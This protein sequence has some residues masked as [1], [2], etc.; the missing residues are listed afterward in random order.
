M[1]AAFLVCI[2]LAMSSVLPVN[3]VTIPDGRALTPAGFTVPVDSFVTDEVLSPDGNWLAVVGQGSGAVDVISTHDSRLKARLPIPGATA[4]AWTRTGLYVARGYSGRVSRFAYAGP[5]LQLAPLPDLDA[6]AG[7]INGVADE[8]VSHRLALARTAAREVDVFDDESGRMLDVLPT[9]GQPYRVGFGGNTL[10][11]TLYDSDHVRAWRLD[12]PGDVHDI[13]TGAHPSALLVDGKRFFVANSDGN[14][15]VIINA[16]LMLERRFSLASVAGSLPGQT[17]AGMALSADGAQLYVTE[18]GMNDV[19]VVDVATGRI[20][21]RIPT[22]WYPTAVASL[23]RPTVG[24][25]DTRMRQQLW[26]ADAK[27]SGSQP[28]P[29]GEWDGTYT[30]LVQHLI[31]DPMQF[32]AWSSAVARNNRVARAPARAN[33]IPA[34]KHVVFIV[35]ENKHFDESFGDEQEANADPTLLLYGRHITPNAH[36]LAESYTLFDNFMG[37]GEASIYGHSWSTQGIVNDYQER[38][39]HLERPA[40]G[41][42]V[43]LVPEQIWPWPLVNGTSI[44]SADMDFDWFRNLADLGIA[45]R[46]NVSGVFGPRGELID[47]FQRRKISYR[48]YGEQMTVLPDGQIAPGLAAHADQ[49][50]PGDHVDFGVLD[51]TRAQE[52]LEDVKAHGLAAYSYMTLP[53]DHTVGTAPGEYTP[54]SFIASNDRALGL[55][56][57]GLSRRPDWK[58]TIVFVTTDDP[59]GTGDHVDA[60]RM[61]ALIVGPYIR[62]H[63]VAH[64]RYSFPSFLRTVELIFGLAP[65]NIEDALAPPM[66]D[67]FA[68]QPIPQAFE[69]LPQAVPMELNPGQRRKDVSYTIDGADSTAIPAQEWVSINGPNS[70]QHHVAYM[71]SLGTSVVVLRDR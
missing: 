19:A 69:A 35:H 64:A 2:L 24:G 16:S 48:V 59:Q 32:A 49:Q 22:A 68:I 46:V 36:A 58:D 26:I 60:H 13:Q 62:R 11:A 39:A 29:G 44:P 70:Y 66:T 28:D 54:E 67:I 21:T 33:G 3:A 61:P 53:T 5:Q 7:L 56:V 41:D 45:P 43:A 4:A 71:R 65:L 15:V 14:D 17:P 25:K 52:F 9:S 50:F 1:K 23:S 51:T 18:S 27:G 63:F 47:E 8:P 12:V 42:S 10:V 38:N 20:L 57:A 40:K 31:V 6:G 34:I 37:N 30:G 55:I